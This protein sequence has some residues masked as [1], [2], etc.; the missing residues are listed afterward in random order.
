METGI[1]IPIISDYGFKATFGNEAD[2]LFLR[3]ALQALIKSETPI[4]EVRFDKNVFEALTID[5]RS[6]IFDLACTDENGSQFIVEMQ[7]GLAPHFVQR[8][9]F[10]ALH[11]FN[12]VVERGEFDY[13]NL[14][15]IYAIAILAKSILPTAHFHTVANLR[16]EAGEIIDTQ[17]TFITVELAKFNKL[18]TEIETVLDKLVYTMKTLH[19]TEP[20]QYPAFWNEE[21][22]KRAIDELDT[23]KMTTEERAY[24]A[25][26][27]AANAEAVKAE[28]QKIREAVEQKEIQAI[29]K[30]LKGGKLTIE[31]IAEYNGTSV[32]FVLEVQRSL[33]KNS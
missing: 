13:A 7:L 21:W 14:P 26:V 33:S 12:T 29:T 10:Y 17:M 25:R 11:K 8:M 1:Y 4:R 23:R 27:T 5:S 31:E 9:K 22:L 3:T 18:V 24:F 30:A 6:G 2:S 32:D 15:K 16:S 20:T 28:K 19:T